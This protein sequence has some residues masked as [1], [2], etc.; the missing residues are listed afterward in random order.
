MSVEAMAWARKQRTKSAYEKLNLIL[1]ADHADED[2][3]CW[4]SQKL[5]MQDGVQSADTVQRSMAGLEAG[6]FIERVR[7]HRTK[8]CWP[9]TV[10]RLAIGRSLDGRAAESG[11]A[12]KPEEKQARKAALSGPVKSMTGPLTAVPP[13][14]SQRPHRA[15]HSGLEPSLETSSEP[16]AP[17]LPKSASRSCDQR[18]RSRDPLP[19]LVVAALQRRLGNDV[20]ASWFADVNFIGTTGG[21]VTISAGTKFKADHLNSQYD[22]QMLEAWRGVDQSVRRVVAVFSAVAEAHL[23]PS[24]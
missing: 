1:L 14:R 11:L 21:E 20:V 24:T 2:G 9:G 6:G 19:P 10:Y 16:S 8:G 22:A 3:I 13:D 4:P 17:K 23:L 15:A 12:G 5:L 18:S 7:R